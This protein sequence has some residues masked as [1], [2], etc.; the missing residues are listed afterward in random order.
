MQDYNV[1]YETIDCERT[2]A[3]NLCHGS[4]IF[5]QFRIFVKIFMLCRFQH[6]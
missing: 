2:Q 4:V 6:N 3:R 5:V 1:S